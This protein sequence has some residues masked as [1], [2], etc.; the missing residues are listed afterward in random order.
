MIVRTLVTAIE[1][2]SLLGLLSTKEIPPTSREPALRSMSDLVETGFARSRV[3]MINEAHDGLRRSVR[4][5][6]AGSLILPRAHAAGVRHIA[7]EALTP[8]FAR[9][10][11]QTRTLPHGVSYLAQPEMRDFIRAALD[12][13]WTL[14]S[15]DVAGDA[16]AEITS[17]VASMNWR[18]AQQAANIAEVLENIGE[19]E[20]LLVWSGNSHLSERSGLGPGGQVFKPMGVQFRDLTGIDPFTIDQTVTVDFDGTGERGRMWIE[21]FSRDLETFPLHT[22]G[23]LVEELGIDASEDAWVFSLEN[24][25]SAMRVIISCLAR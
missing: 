15:Y 17:A 23:A 3:V 16:P 2:L 20:R 12:L 21:R 4:N 6:V 14:H 25:L 18:E 8:D 5:R 10:A 13:G 24:E 9:Q 11:N 22:A 7:M 1:S 19:G